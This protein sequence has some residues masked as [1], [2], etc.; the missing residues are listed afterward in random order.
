[1]KVWSTVK[2]AAVLLLATGGTAIAE[3]GTTTNTPTHAECEAVFKAKAAAGKSVSTN[4]LAEQLQLPAD[5]VKAC[6]RMQRRGR[7]RP[8]PASGT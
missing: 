1:M 7:H 6:I 8:T 3:S 5:K 2:I 4:Q